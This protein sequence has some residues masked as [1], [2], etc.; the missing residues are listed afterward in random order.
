MGKKKKKIKKIP[1]LGY[2]KKF[3]ELQGFMKKGENT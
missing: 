1:I 3:K 2:F